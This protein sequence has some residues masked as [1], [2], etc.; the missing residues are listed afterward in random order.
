[1][2]LRTVKIF[3]DSLKYLVNYFTQSFNSAAPCKMVLFICAGIYVFIFLNYYFLK[4][5]LGVDQKLNAVAQPLITHVVVT[6]FDLM[7]GGVRA[8]VIPLGFRFVY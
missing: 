1:M 8:S 2:A 7:Q 5:A 3:K 6:Y 4:E